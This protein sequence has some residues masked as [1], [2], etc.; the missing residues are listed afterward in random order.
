MTSETTMALRFTW[1]RI[2]GLGFGFQKRPWPGDSPGWLKIDKCKVQSVTDH[3]TFTHS[4][5]DAH[6]IPKSEEQDTETVQNK[7][8][9][10]I[11]VQY[12]QGNSRKLTLRMAW[13]AKMA[14]AS[15]R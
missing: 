4:H 6:V 12:P 1:F 7:S 13:N 8:F 11:I 3:D 5:P 10:I 2:Y 15:T 9:T 14:S